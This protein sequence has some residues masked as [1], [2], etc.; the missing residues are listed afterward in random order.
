MT[1]TTTPWYAESLTVARRI[2][3]DRHRA[4]RRAAV[5]AVSALVTAFVG[6]VLVLVL[7]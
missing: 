1:G 6:V 2:A 4:R 7:G 3:A 5:V